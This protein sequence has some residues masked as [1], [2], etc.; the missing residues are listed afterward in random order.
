MSNSVL[1]TILQSNFKT[2]SYLQDIPVLIRRSPIFFL[3]RLNKIAGIVVPDRPADFSGLHSAVLKQIFCLIK[4]GI[5]QDLSEI[6]PIG[7]ADQPAD[8]G[9]AEMKVFR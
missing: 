3:K 8:I 7:S 4:P 2:L 9:G 1:C 6:D 5:A